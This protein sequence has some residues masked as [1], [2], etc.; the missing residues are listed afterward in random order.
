MAEPLIALRGDA[1]R[2]I[3]M[4]HVERLRD[5][6]RVLAERGVDHVHVCDAE[7]RAILQGRG[8]PAG[9]IRPVEEGWLAAMAPSHV[10]TDL[11]WSGNAEHAAREIAALTASGCPVTVIDSMPPDHF[12]TPPGAVPPACVVTPYLGAETLRPPPRCLDWAVG[13]GFAVID[14]SYRAAR[15][16]IAPPLPRRVLVS[17]GGS[18]PT[19]LSV[20]VARRLAPTRLDIDLVMGP[21]YAEGIRTDLHRIAAD[22]PNLRLLGPQPGLAAL[23]ESCGLVVGRIGLLRYQAAVL[24]RSGLYLFEGSQYRAYLENF[25][26]AGLAEVFFADP[27]AGDEPFLDRLSALGDPGVQDALFTL[28]TAAMDAVHGNGAANVVDRVLKQRRI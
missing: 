19:G 27:P 1:S 8:V 10:I 14:A 13:A 16:R 3:G 24:G 9:R 18:D 20:R 4:G 15:A 28:N 22:H 21:L 26:R 25:A 17:C 12:V 11:Q 2:A 5:L 7:T 23:V 6:G